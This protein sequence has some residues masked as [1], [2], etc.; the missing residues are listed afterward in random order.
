MYGESTTMTAC[1]V[2][3]DTDCKESWPVT[4]MHCYGYNI[5]YL[6][7]IGSCGRYCMGMCYEKRL[8]LRQSSLQPRDKQVKI[9]NL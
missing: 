6:T 2:G 4:V 9:S 7:Q 5:A 1:M 3:N 8:V